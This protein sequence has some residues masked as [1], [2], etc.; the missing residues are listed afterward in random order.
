MKFNRRQMLGLGVLLFGTPA[1]VSAKQGAG[2]SPLFLSAAS[3]ADDKHW[4]TGFTFTEAGAVAVFKSALPERAHHIAVNQQQ[5]FFVVVARRPGSWLSLGDLA[6]GT[7]VREIRVPADRHVFGHGIFSADGKHFYTTESDFE[8]QQ[9]DS[10][11]V[12][13]WEVSGEGSTVDLTRVQEFPSY[14]VGPHELLLMPDDETLAIAN[15]GIRTHPAH[16]RDNLNVDSM[17]PS[18]AYINR[19][20][21]E[22]LEQQ[23]LPQEF[24][25]ASIR[26]MDVNAAGRIIIGMQFEGEPFLEVPLV[27]THQ[28]GEELKLLLAPPEVQVQMKQYVGSM[29][30]AEDGRHFVASCPVGNM[31]TF[32]DA[33]DGV[34]VNSI[35]ARDGCG[36]C[37]TDTGFAFSTGTGRLAHIELASGV[38][39]EHE[40]SQLQ[41]LFWD[42]HLTLVEVGTK[43]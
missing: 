19:N 42:N 37:A 21:G 28:R 35:R 33:E 40:E 34:M 31:L 1:L 26:H 30:F 8:D 12:V 41:Q 29:R 38:I 39:T 11:R 4:V 6:T 23:F 9:G 14:G 36:V 43:S 27:A 16:D 17:V 7:I 25:Q 13:V 22:L 32:W 24:H 10:G 20:T 2:Q 15:G 3:D 18:L 5:G